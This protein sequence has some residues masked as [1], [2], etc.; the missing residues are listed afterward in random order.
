[1]VASDLA[2]KLLAAG[3][4]AC[5][6]ILCAAADAEA[7]PFADGS[8]DRVLCGLGLMFFPDEA[9]ALA[10]MRRV[11]RPG[12]RAVLSVWGEDGQAPLIECALACMRRLLPAPKVARRSPFRLAPLLPDLL[13]R[14]GF[15]D[16]ET[17]VC[18]LEFAYASAADY[19]QAFLDIAG[20]AAGSLSRLPA[21]IQAR[22]P[23]EVAQELAPHRVGGEFRLA[24]KVL[25]AAAA[26]DAGDA[27][28]RP[29]AV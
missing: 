22:F 15:A 16:I 10:E 6:E 3:R 19:W 24:N 17:T 26:K 13:D 18:E 1:M 25:I 8:F 11:L 28:D 23:L 4:G 7:L 2:E 21:A 29:A 20:G 9:R 14:A 5:P 27:A 12:G